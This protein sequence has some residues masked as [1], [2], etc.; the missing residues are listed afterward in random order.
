MLLELL[1]SPP[2]LV[3]VSLVKVPALKAAL[4]ECRTVAVLLH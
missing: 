1:F 2:V 3:Q 4:R